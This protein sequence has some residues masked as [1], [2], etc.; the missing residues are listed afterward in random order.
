MMMGFPTILS[1]PQRFAAQGLPKAGVL[2]LCLVAPM[3]PA[4]AVPQLL[5]I[6]AA[7][8]QSPDAYLVSGEMAVKSAML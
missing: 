6:P 8:A 5:S 2:P 1:Q 4:L 3:Q 7:Q